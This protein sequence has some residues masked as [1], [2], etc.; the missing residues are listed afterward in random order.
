MKVGSIIRRVTNDG[1]CIGD[2]IV[3]TS[4]KSST[5]YG[6]YLTNPRLEEFRID[7]KMFKEMTVARLQVGQDDFRCIYR[8]LVTTYTHKLTPTWEKAAN[9]NYD[10]I[11]IYSKKHYMY[12]KN[13]EFKKVVIRN[14][15]KYEPHVKIYLDTRIL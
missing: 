1:I 11:K 10:M 5:L 14:G 12:F 8:G 2:Y 15:Y 13:C 6:M 4:K 7:E 9:G 3:I